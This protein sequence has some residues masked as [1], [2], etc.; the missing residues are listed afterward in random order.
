[1]SRARVSTSSSTTSR[2]GK[3]EHCNSRSWDD[4]IDS[5]YGELCSLRTTSIR[6]HY[7]SSDAFLVPRFVNTTLTSLLSQILT[8]SLVVLSLPHEYNLA[9]NRYSVN[10]NLRI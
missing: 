5:L 8:G 2:T 1:M 10:A 4:K 9:Q 7:I 6:N 3:G